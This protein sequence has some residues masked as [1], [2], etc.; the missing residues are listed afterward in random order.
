[1]LLL[2]LATLLAGC[3][4]N[5]TDTNK[6]PLTPEA[7]LA[8]FQIKTG[9][10]IKLLAAEPLVMDP[11]AMDVDELGR[12]FVVEM[13]G[14]PLKTDPSGRV[15]LL[16][17]TDGD[18]Y[19]DQST[20]F[21]DNLTLPNGVMR[22]KQ[23]ILVTA[24]PDIWYL[25]DTDGDNV[26]DVRQVV[27]TGF[28]FSNPQHT[29][30]DPVY[31][32]D[33]WIYISHEPAVNTIIFTEEFGDAGSEIYF[34]ERPETPRLK[35]EGRNIRF[36]LDTFEIETLAGTSQFGQT[37]DSWGRHFT[38]NNSNH[39]RHEVIHSRYL[40]RNPHLLVST[41]M[42]NMSDHGGAAQIFPTTRNPRYEML[43][44]IGQITS[45]CGLTLYL[46]DAFPS[47]FERTSFVAEPAHNLV[48]R[49]VW[50]ESGSTFVASRASNEKEFLTSTD[51]WFRPVSF[52]IGPE[53]ALYLVD[54]Y[55]EVIEHPEWMAR[56]AY[57]S[58]ALYGGTNRGRLYKIEPET[59][60]TPETDL[61][62]DKAEIK[63]LVSA[64]ERPNI[65]WRRTAQR[66]LV[67]RRD[68]SSVPLLTDLASNSQYPQARVHALWTLD[69]LGKLN[70]SLIE[71]A[72]EHS[73]AGVRQN[74]VLLAEPLLSRTPHLVEKL[75][76]MDQDPDPK[77]R[78]QLLCTLGNINTQRALAA[79][80]QL[81]FEDIDDP[82]MQ[83]AG[84]S[85]DSNSAPR[86]F[87]AAVS[88]A[89]LDS[90]Q[91]YERFFRQVSAIIGAQGNATEIKTVLNLASRRTTDI[92]TV[93]LT[94]CL[95]GLSKG[96][97]YRNPQPIIQKEILLD[98]LENPMTRLRRAALGLLEVI[99]FPSSSS[100]DQKVSAA[101]NIAVDARTDTE[102]RADAIQ[103][104][105]ITEPAEFQ[106][107]LQKLVNPSQPEEIQAAALSAL[108]QI[109]GPEIAAFVLEH[110]SAMTPA[111]RDKA[112]ETFFSDLNRPTLLVEALAQGKIQPWTLSFRSRRRLMM[113]RN[114]VLREKARTLLSATTKQRQ[115][116]IQ[117]Y[118]S[119]LYRPGDSTRGGAI[120]ERECSRCHKL[121]GIGQQFG[122]DLATVRNRPIQ[123]LLEDI[124]I[125]NS[126]IAQGYELYVV[127]L[128]DG[129]NLEGVIAD[130]TSS[131]LRLVN[132]EGKENLIVRTEISEMYAAQL[133]AMPDGLEKQID[134]VEMVDL[135]AFLKKSK[136]DTN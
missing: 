126:S 73:E 43:T 9:F 81:L 79:R 124:L 5:C 38:V 63:D 97:A 83:I 75:L 24:A 135:L 132:E 69:A 36:K 21:A 23:G 72:L 33:N 22:W 116:V 10:K 121:G 16:E 34:P 109:Q 12:I 115:E 18:G 131:T 50:S 71:Q 80:E 59:G 134:P 6:P 136:T 123:I 20:I 110:W 111:V 44:S 11:V 42:Q 128:R 87:Q 15:R 14:Y 8:N 39:V 90:Q 95:E 86:L 99:G 3:G 27:L 17:D 129:M 92:S 1:M 118:R 74:A 112:A 32:L 114:P 133:S 49:D 101:A 96:L 104:L 47:G 122:P 70:S 29:I 77:V 66:L 120:F 125:P 52:Y 68:P 7:T 40:A 57:E 78:F 48:H 82:W 89:S 106:E 19:P 117:N 62:L 64:L 58:G 91:S 107:L 113:H 65:W 127:N 41:A 108:G 56:E 35:N 2:F 46:G 119:I 93:W 60:L 67:D 85:A 94:A 100:L 28:A 84:L 103:L 30:S 37:F 61:R 31:G 25:E 55:R 105:A 130:Q 98:L 53:G 4:R 88:H 54:Y 102:R 13:P 51:S 76:Q 45:A 26:A